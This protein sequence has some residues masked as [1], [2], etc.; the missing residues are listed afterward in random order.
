MKK[1]NNKIWAFSLAV[2]GSALLTMY[3]CKKSDDSNSNAN[4]NGPV[5]T[6]SAVTNITS[7]TAAC[8]G[9]ISNAGGRTIDGR[10]V[11]WG[12]AQNPTV[13][14]STFD[15]TGREALQAAS[16]VLHRIQLIM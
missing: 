12:T 10:G 1:R 7:S 5:I 13:S 16:Q 6:T 9:N 3:G 11:C 15:G 2:M 8:G 4:G 14:K